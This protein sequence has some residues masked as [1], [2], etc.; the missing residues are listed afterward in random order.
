MSDSKKLTKELKDG[1]EF[2]F[3]G[4]KYVLQED[5]DCVGCVECDFLGLEVNCEK[6]QESGTIPHCSAYHRKDD[7]CHVFIEK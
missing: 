7:T 1:D 5:I 3:K 6:L 4:V 2:I